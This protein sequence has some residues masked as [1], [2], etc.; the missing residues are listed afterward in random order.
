MKIINLLLI[1]ILMFTQVAQAKYESNSND[2]SSVLLYGKTSTGTLTPLLVNSSG[3]VQTQTHLGFIA[4]RGLTQ[5]Q[6][7]NSGF[8]TW[9]CRSRHVAMDNMNDVKI[10]LQNFYSWTTKSEGGTG[11]TATVSASIEYPINT[12][13]QITFN[14]GLTTATIASGSTVFSDLVTL[15]STI[16]AGTPFWIRIY[17]ANPNGI[18]YSMVGLAGDSNYEAYDT[19]ASDNTMN[20]SWV[21][22]N[23]FANNVYYPAAVIGTTTKPSVLILGDSRAEGQGDTTDT[24][25]LSG[26]ERFIGKFYAYSNQ[27]VPGEAFNG[28]GSTYGWNQFHT[29]RMKLAPYATHVISNYGIND[30]QNAQSTANIEI[31]I[32]NLAALFTIPVYWMTYEPITTSSDT[33]ATQGNQT[34]NGTM[35]TKW[36]T[37]NADLRRMSIPGVSGVI[38]VNKVAESY[39]QSG[40]WI[41]NGTASYYTADGIHASANLNKLYA[42]SVNMPFLISSNNTSLPITGG[43]INGDVGFNGKMFNTGSVCGAIGPVGTCWTSTGRLGYC[44][45]AA[46]VCTTCTAC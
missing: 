31:W 35:K 14:N 28:D 37:I 6:A 4:T 24:T 39:Q 30:I 19:S 1:A 18:I 26:Y 8:T 23:T 43:V 22:T 41:T 15:A 36:D 34:T 46:N 44:S 3:S 38:D 9:T 29:E 25:E 33:W 32:K 2:A 7:I 5:L 16:P 11:A 13:K 20:T 17:Y 45:G 21:P 42:D 12:L 27:A 10:A 40:K